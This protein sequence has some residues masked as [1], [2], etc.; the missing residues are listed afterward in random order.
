LLGSQESSNSAV[1]AATPE[2]LSYLVGTII[3][4]TGSWSN[5]GNTREM[6]MDWNLNTYFDAP[7]GTNAWVGLDLGTNS[8]SVI[9]KICFCPRATWSSRMVGGV[10]QGANAS[11]FSDAV[12]LFTITTQPTDGVMT[13]LLNANTTPFRYVRYLSPPNGWGN[14]AELAFY[15]PGPHIS[16]AAGAVL[17]TAGNSGSADTNA[18]DTNIATYFDCAAANGNWAGLDLGNAATIT[19]VRFC[20]R[21]GDDAAMVGGIFQGANT[22][23]FS[24]AVNLWTITNV[25][26]DATLTAQAVNNTNGYRYV[27]YLSP[28]GSYGDVAEVQFF[29]SST[30][31]SELPAAPTGLTTSPGVQEVGLSWTASSGAL[32][33]NVKRGTTS[34]GPYTNIINRTA[35]VDMDIGLPY[36][37]YYY[38]VSAVNAAGESANSAEAS[39]TLGCSVLA[40]PGDL[41]VT[42]ENGQLVLTWAAVSN[43][44]IASTANAVSYN[45]LRATS[46]AG[47]FVLVAAGVTTT[48]FTDGTITNQNLYYYEVQ[49]VNACGASTNSAPVSGSLA[50]LNVQPALAPV[51]NQSIMAGQTLVITNLAGDVLAPPQLLSYALLAAPAGADINV[52]NGVVRWRPTVAQGGTT[53]LLAVAVANNGLP[54]LSA[55]QN[56]TVT[57]LAPAQP[58]FADYAVSNGIFGAAITGDFGPDYS[59]LSSTDLV[60]WALVS[61]AP[62]PQLP[63]LFSAPGVLGQTATFYR[64]RLGP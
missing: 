32:T 60:N 11:D 42:A 15:T 7:I 19:A 53:N 48:S 54:T 47:P 40:A 23:T 5:S 13:P 8:A 10:F 17:G 41:A 12:T 39:A 31:A 46:S 45:V 21:S 38:V 64:V 22:G 24:G 34:G 58:V 28:A 2:S 9:S 36:G 57:V 62:Q 3:G 59:I 29:T 35:T 25:P 16:L 61:T 37:T 44:V 1:A 27:R 63:L 18:F 49:T 50:G 51:P 6:A 52:S 56:F 33:Y 4:T 43:N 26:A 14:V 20:P 55:M 30:I